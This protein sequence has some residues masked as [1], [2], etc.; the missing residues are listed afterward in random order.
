VSSA[1]VL[2]VHNSSLIGGGN[3]VLLGLFDRLKRDGVTPIS[4]LPAVGPMEGELKAR[5]VPYVVL[6]L[7]EVLDGGY[8]DTI[9][10]AWRLAQ[11]MMR[12][13]VA[14]LHANGPG[15]YRVASLAARLTR[16]PRVCHLHLPPDPAELVWAFG[17]RPHVAIACSDD[18]AR[19]AS[20]VLSDLRV[21]SIPNG[22][23]TEALRPPDDVVALRRRLGIT[24]HAPVVSIVG[25]VSERKGH[26]Y[27]LEMA[28]DL[29]LAHPDVRY[30]VVG[31]DILGEGAYRHQ[32][33]AYARALG[34]A[35]RVRFLGF[36]HDA[37]EWIAAS[38]VIVLPSLEE[39][40]PV[41]LLEAGATAKPT[42][43]TAVNG[44]P[45]MVR[46]G[47]TGF[48]VPPRDGGELT[49]AVARLLAD[50]GLRVEMGREARKRV[51]ET[52]SVADQARAVLAL[53]RELLDPTREPAA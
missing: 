44:S 39:G 38:D 35:D 21:V 24:P 7:R 40:L 48:L 31:E 8:R 18:V 19:R 32:M 22:V 12:R 53:Y 13:R 6:A 25:L 23:D 49:R 16:R 33:E 27:F 43:A 46:D 14:L 3:R 37:V 1:A 26:R 30:L 42:V 52:F 45:E 9:R 29:Q 4:V 20:A 36:R 10:A 15:Y 41:S 47:I 5:G 34:I 51:E 2:Y 50:E 17:I 28:R 11:L